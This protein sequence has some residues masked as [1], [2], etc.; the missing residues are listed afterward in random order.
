MKLLRSIGGALLV[1]LILGL[2]AVAVP[3][4]AQTLNSLTMERVL[5]LSTVH[6]S[7]TPNLPASLLGALT[8]GAQEIHE[9]TNYNPQASLVTET[10]FVLPA[11][12]PLPTSLSTVPVTSYILSFAM[13]IDKT[14]VTSSAVQFVGTISQ[15]SAPLV[16][17]ASYQ[18]S[19]ATLSF[20]YTKDTPPK[21]HD[22]IESIAGVVVSYT[23]AATGTFNITLPPTGGGGGGGG[24]GVTI[25]VNGATGTTP[26]FQ[27]TVN[28]LTLDASASSSTNAGALTYT[29]SIPQGSPSAGISFPG[30]NTAVAFVQLSSGKQTY[31]VN[32][33]V[34]DATGAT[35]TATITIV[36]L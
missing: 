16:G 9:Q 1:V 29:W 2:L 4:G 7:L 35:A 18:G 8:S 10:L 34:T 19:P 13:S 24:T 3:A 25:V 12:S 36:F 14:Y 21:I 23:G 26:S 32:L 31:T 11:G 28:Q 27:T 22:V 30:A 15:S 17:S 33:T 20:G 6:S 5:V